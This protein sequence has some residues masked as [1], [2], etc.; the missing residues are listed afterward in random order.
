MTVSDAGGRT[1][2][3]KARPRGHESTG[4]RHGDGAGLSVT[5]TP[6]QSTVTNLRVD[7][8]RPGSESEPEPR[9]LPA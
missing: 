3:L 9:S 5:L 4:R 7:E 1:L 2:N 8:T 6:S